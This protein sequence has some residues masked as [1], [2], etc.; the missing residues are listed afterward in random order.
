M[1][2]SMARRGTVAAI[3]G[4]ALMAMA[5]SAVG[6]GKAPSKGKVTIKGAETFQPN[7]YLKIGFHFAPGTVTIKSGGTITLTNTTSD[8][9]TLSIVKKSQVP[10]TVAQLENCEVCGAILKSHGINPEGPPQHGPPPILVAN[11]GAEGFNVP[12]DS[13]VIGPKGHHST[14]A[15]K[16]TAPAGTVLNFICGLHPWMQGRFL[17]K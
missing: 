10:R 6:A 17:V 3:I 15:F 11:V 4:V 7:S 12:G 16:V 5:A 2:S 9:H 1:R 8:A 14:V 13:L